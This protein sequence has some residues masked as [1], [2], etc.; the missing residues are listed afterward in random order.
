MRGEE[1][2]GGYVYKEARTAAAQSLLTWSYLVELGQ[3]VAALHDAGTGLLEDVGHGHQLRS[4][5]AEGQR[6]SVD[7]L[8]IR[9][10]QDN[11]AFNMS[12]HPQVR[13]EIALDTQ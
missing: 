8:H 5:R 4:R 6:L 3:S 2:Q 11:K 12:K 7:L 1:E 10:I 13:L 9:R